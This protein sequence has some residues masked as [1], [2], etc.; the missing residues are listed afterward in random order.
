MLSKLRNSTLTKYIWGFMGLYLLNI[1]V[2]TADPNPQYIAEDLTFNDQESIIEIIVEKVLGFEDA[3]DE[4]DDCD[5]EDYNNKK[6]VKINILI[7]NSP[8][9]NT[10]TLF[11]LKKEKLFINHKGSVLIG[12]KEIDSPPPQV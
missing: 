8:S 6:Q 9:K 2:D 1:C 11:S 5:T 12:F 7:N 4:Y 3:I 10:T